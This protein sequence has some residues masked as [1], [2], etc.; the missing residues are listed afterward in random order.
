MVFPS[1]H[2]FPAP[3]PSRK[4]DSPPLPDELART[5]AGLEPAG[6]APARRG[7]HATVSRTGAVW[8]GIWAGV[9]VLILT[10]IFVAQNTGGVQI[11]FLWMQGR[12]PLAL[13]LLIAG[14]AG[15]VVA[16][17]VASARILQLRRL[18][19]RTRP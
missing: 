15:A 17:S 4:P 1:G 5:L 6:E 7:A 8:Y 10:I 11:S 12:I 14:V 9:V 16:M 2:D 18:V 3:D 19:R 13:A